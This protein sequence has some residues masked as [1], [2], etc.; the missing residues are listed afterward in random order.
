MKRKYD[1]DITK[2]GIPAMWEKGGSYSNTG[3]ATIIADRNGYPKR[4]VHVR[5]R[6]DLA[7][8]NHALVPVANGDVIVSV[9]RHRDR[10]AVTVER[11]TT[12]F[13]G[14]A[15]TEP[16]TERI[17]FDAIE[18]AVAK[19]NDYHCRQPYYIRGL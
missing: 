7:C 5:T 11:I 6:G 10:V 12:I 13:D 18:A 2:S 4:A 9:N 1:I 16:C 14:T 17:C 15:Q 8:S 3:S 19:A